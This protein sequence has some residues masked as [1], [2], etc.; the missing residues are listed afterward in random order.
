MENLDDPAVKSWFRS[1]ADYTSS[2]LARIPGRAALLARIHQLDNSSAYVT[3]VQEAG[4]YVFYEKAR[5]QDD[6]FKLYVRR[7]VSGLERVLFDPLPL[8]V[9]GV[10]TSLDYYTPSLDG[11]HVAYGTSPGGSEDSTIHVL[12]TATGKVLP[13]AISRCQF[14][15]GDIGWLPDNRSFFYNREQLL[16]PGQNPADKESDSKVYLHHLGDGPDIQ[17]TPL[18]GKGINAAIPFIDADVPF[19]LTSPGAPDSVFAVNDRGVQNEIALW[20]APLASLNGAPA[21]IPWTK[22]CDFTDDVTGYDVHGG[23][24]YLLS[25]KGA[26]H[27]QI[28]ETSLTAPDV[29]H[30]RIIAATDTI[31]V[32]KGL[33]AASDALYVHGRKGAVG[34]LTRIPY[35][36]GRATSIQMPFIGALDPTLVTDPRIPGALFYT[37]S[38]AHYPV[39]LRYNSATMQIADTHLAPKDPTDFSHVTQA[40]VQ[41][42]APDGT[43]IP[44]SVMYPKGM[45]FDGSHPTVMEGYGAYGISTDMS[46]FPVLLSWVE[47]GG[48][49]AVAHVRGGGEEGQDW[50]QAGY[51]AT[52]PN[53]WQDFIACGEYLVS[54]K[55]TSR[56]SWRA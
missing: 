15:S 12:E 18:L 46:Y 52:K 49:V 53:T 47:R 54:H 44:L 37:Q 42:T 41:A 27:F 17:N 51:K 4:P 48:V 43:R 56:P 22:V 55:Y 14:D 34:Y 31:A 9:K 23:H 3:D 35:D 1:Q 29:A 36:G 25:H 26:P 20:I 5:P 11:S 13:D 28:L 30:A 50:Y 39:W 10:H 45:K 40:E 21:Q 24:I 7:G 6:N 2:V 16:T 8:T 33:G 38:G 19:L 32:A